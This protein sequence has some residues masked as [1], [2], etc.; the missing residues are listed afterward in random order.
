MSWLFTYFWKQVRSKHIRYPATVFTLKMSKIKGLFPADAFVCVP[1]FEGP[2]E[3]PVTVARSLGYRDGSFSS[4]SLCVSSTCG[5]F[6]PGAPRRLSVRMGPR[7]LPCTQAPGLLKL[8]GPRCCS[9][10]ESLS[11]TSPQNPVQ[12]VA[13]FVSL[14]LPLAPITPCPRTA[15][16]GN[17]SP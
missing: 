15:H 12:T 6:C 17:T 1:G 10:V 2:L 4:P 8:G 5:S 13:F 7:W 3:H 14:P 16:P 9:P 11:W